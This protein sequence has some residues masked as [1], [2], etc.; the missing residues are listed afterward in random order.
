MSIYIHTK[1]YTCTCVN[2][3]AAEQVY[4]VEEAIE[5]MGFGFFQV[6]LTV[7]SGLI[8]VSFGY[9]LSMITSTETKNSLSKL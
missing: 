4:T 2:V 8:W 6:L 9:W 3:T 7:F 5:K 1:L